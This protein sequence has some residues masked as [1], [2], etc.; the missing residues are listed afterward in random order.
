MTTGAD[1]EFSEAD[2]AAGRLKSTLELVRD[3]EPASDPLEQ[4]AKNRILNLLENTPEPFSRH[5]FV[6]GHITASALVLLP[7]TGSI[8]LVKHLKLG[9]WLQPG[10]HTEPEDRFPR[11]TALREAAEEAGVK[12]DRGETAG[13]VA[14]DVHAIPASGKEPHHEHFDLMFG[15]SAAD[16][17]LCPSK[18]V[19]DAVWCEPGDLTKYEIDG[20]LIRGLSRIG[21][22]AA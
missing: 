21:W 19:G 8:L 5:Q 7:A 14:L 1:T 10:G 17:G 22:R 18:E 16:T 20:P 9:R 15:F 6:P 12:I 3:F 2:F 13:L 4:L 11:D